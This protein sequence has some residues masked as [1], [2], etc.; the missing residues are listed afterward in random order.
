[1]PAAL[2][3]MAETTLSLT[4]A[5]FRAIMP[6]GDVSYIPGVVLMVETIRSSDNPAFT[7]LMTA[8]LLS[9]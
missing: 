6:S 8:S 2:A 5:L 3:M 4:P 1:V 9:S 7:N